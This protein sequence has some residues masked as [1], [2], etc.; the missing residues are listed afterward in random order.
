MKT[1]IRFGAFLAVLGVAATASA[2]FGNR[3]NYYG[4][5]GSGYSPAPAPTRQQ[6]TPKPT[7]RETVQ[8]AQPAQ[9]QAPYRRGEIFRQ[10]N[11]RAGG[12]I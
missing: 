12:N 1:I 11:E 3:T 9:S 8:P 2:N 7:Q 6:E 5:R 4:N 10:I